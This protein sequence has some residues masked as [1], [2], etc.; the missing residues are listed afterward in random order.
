MI[1]RLA[2][3]FAMFQ[4]L[5]HLIEGA[6]KLAQFISPV[7]QSRACAKIARGQ[8]RAGFHQGPN[9]TQDQ[10]V[11]ADP[12][13]HKSKAGGNPQPGQAFGQPAIRFGKENLP[14]DAA[15]NGDHVVGNELAAHGGERMITG[16]SIRR[17]RLHHAVIL[18]EDGFQKRFFRKRPADPFFRRGIT[19]QNF[20]GAVNLGPRRSFG[21]LR[22]QRGI[23]TADPVQ[24]QRGK[25]HRLDLPVGIKNRITEIDGGLAGRLSVREI[26]NREGA[27]CER[28][29]EKRTVRLVGRFHHRARA[30][31]NHSI[32]PDHSQIG[33]TRVA[34]EQLVQ[35]FLAA[36]PA[37]RAH[38]R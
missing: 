27:R 18:T 38:W 24:I 14:G 35:Q 15:E 12:A 16:N 17:H 6:G 19:N 34:A 9:R 5:G 23:E 31:Q 30:G 32:G 8:P 11:A 21:Q 22:R 26:A 25:D 29:A 3:P 37:A 33:I 2:F 4:G 13:E 10:Q 20:S 7:G 28:A 36:P 1:C